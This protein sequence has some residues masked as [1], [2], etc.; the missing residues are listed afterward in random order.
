MSS[1]TLDEIVFDDS[2]Y[3]RATWSQATVDRY[4]DALHADEH[5]P[6]IVLEAGTRRLLDGKH[7]IEAHRA[8]GRHFI[9]ADFHEIPEGVP[10]VLYA[11]SLSARHGDPLAVEDKRRVA[12]EIAESN[13]DFSMVLIAQLLGATRQTVSRYVSDLIEHRREVRKAQATLLDRAGWSHRQIGEH[14]GV[15][16]K[17]VG[18]DVTSNISPQSE[19]VLREAAKDLPIDADPIV[20][21]ILAE[22]AGPKPTQIPG[23]VDTTITPV[24]PGATPAPVA[25]A[26]IPTHEPDKVAAGCEKCGAKLATNDAEAGYLRCDDCD[27]DAVHLSATFPDGPGACVACDPAARLAAVAEVAPEFVK[28]VEPEPDPKPSLRIVPTEDEKR[29]AEQRDARG[30]LLRAVEILAPAHD[31]PGFAET[32][33]RQLGPYDAELSD[34]I[35]RATEAMATLDDLIERCGQ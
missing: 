3:P 32:W 11:A 31:R 14:L 23:P 28:P 17:T 7:R 33:A 10:A 15:D 26:P 29:A 19:E 20:E 5:F 24:D 4:A 12:R 13:P 6:A 30:L 9:A 1:V 27:P 18:S 8:A 35:R 16:H 25:D 21:A 34:L 22:R 2:I